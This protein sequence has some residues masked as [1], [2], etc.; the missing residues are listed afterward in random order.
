MSAPAPALA[1]KSQ[2][3]DQ[4][5]WLPI[6]L[7][8]TQNR[9][10]FTELHED[11]LLAIASQQPVADE[12]MVSPDPLEIRRVFAYRLEGDLDK[13]AGDRRAFEDFCLL[14]EGLAYGLLRPQTYDLHEHGLPLKTDQERYI[15]CLFYQPP[16][17]A[18]PTCAG[19]FA[20]DTL[21]C[22]AATWSQR[23]DLKQD[24]ERRRND[25]DQR[26]ARGL[27]HAFR[28]SYRASRM[29][30]AR[31][32]DS[33][34]QLYSYDATGEE[35]QRNLGAFLLQ[36]ADRDR[37]ELQEVFFPRYAFGYLAGLASR[38]NV[39]DAQE[40]GDAVLFYRQN[41]LTCRLAVP[42][43]A[44]Q[45]LFGYGCEIGEPPQ[46]V[47][48]NPELQE[49]A[50][51]ELQP[52]ANAYA[53]QEIPQHPRF[54]LPDCLR[55]VIWQFGE[56]AQLVLRPGENLYAL[57]VLRQVRNAL[58]HYRVTA[59]GL[60]A[61]GDNDFLVERADGSKRAYYV[62]R[63]DNRQV[64]EISRIGRVLWLLFTKEADWNEA[65]SEV[66]YQGRRILW[67]KDGRICVTASVD[68]SA[69]PDPRSHGV[70]LL[71]FVS[72]A[73]HV[74][75]RSVFGLAVRRYLRDYYQQFGHGAPGNPT[76]PFQMGHRTW[77]RLR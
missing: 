27:L 56:A 77:Y 63:Y 74:D 69:R 59:P 26:M 65:K 12:A 14:T 13:K 38:L 4:G 76:E 7:N 8:R 9:T 35:H 11:Q 32:L 25:P 22:P 20:P 66:P 34:L 46:G 16:K 57:W 54:V 47:T 42:Q 51:Q 48:G 21:V 68:G 1:P 37:G 28:E 40:R 18:E 52:F 70:D 30:W 3:V 49:E 45:K 19:S 24:V 2:A 50:L 36:V 10:Q 64:G 41:Q 15:T 43:G 71:A 58:P 72:C 62:E 33:L 23:K 39:D 55:C 75:E 31:A 60:Y 44:R 6:S 73:Q 67:L 29:L 61:E 17:Q 53:G 5:V